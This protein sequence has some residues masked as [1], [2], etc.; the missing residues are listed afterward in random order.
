MRFEKP[1][2]REQIFA[3]M[4]R[5]LRS[6]NREVPE[7][8]DRLDPILRNL[9]QLYSHQIEQ[10]E[11]KIGQVWEAA[12]SSLITSLFPENL[13]WPVPAS[14]IMQCELTDP[15]VDIDP[16]T[17]FIFREKREGGQTFFFAPHRPEKL[18]NAVPVCFLLVA[19]DL[20]ADI[21]YRIPDKSQQKKPAPKT[22]AIDNAQRAYMAI[23]FTGPRADLEGAKLLLVGDSASLKQIRWSHWSL[24]TATGAFDSET[25]FS[26]G[27]VMASDDMVGR[28]GGDRIEWGGLR[29]TNDTLGQ[30]I[31]NFV[32]LPSRFAKTWEKI[33]PPDEVVRVSRQNNVSYGSDEQLYWIR[34]DLPERGEKRKLNTP[35]KV[36]FSGFIAV[37][38]NEQTLF[39]HTGGNKLVEIELP[40]ELSRIL[41][42]TGVVDSS[43]RDYIPAHEID[44]DGK[45]RR[46]SIEERDN[47]LVLWFDFS[48]F[49][50]APPDSLKVTYSVT[51]AA[52]A[53]GIEAGKIAELYEGHPGI[54]S[55]TNL[56]PTSGAIPAL[57]SDQVVRETV[58]RL[59]GRDRALTFSELSRW[60]ETFDPRIKSVE[61]ENSTEK[62]ARG[63]RRCTLVRA[64]VNRE[65]FHSPEETSLLKMRL[66]A[67]LKSRSAVNSQYRVEIEEE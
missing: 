44:V 50:E 37:N 13:R 36:S 21:L 2:T 15:A 41:E 24:S 30:H 19:D 61:C 32:V 22:V 42:V 34:I 45:S 51:A 26:P 17:R 64:K 4:H 35:L 40:E 49:L 48:N 38:K 60:V 55:A 12:T 16:H 5:E 54:V 29:S 52:D 63:V 20:I 1:R 65:S 67:F 18:L 9:L 59:R 53:N 62:S 46:Y 27:L 47:K 6:W 7:S 25:R 28:D 56:T 14:T 33:P 23:R 66:A 39:K 31:D 57:T 58:S 43:G 10:I 8:P 3:A 11:Q